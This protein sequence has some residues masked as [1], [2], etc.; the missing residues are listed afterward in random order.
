LN[1]EVTFLTANSITGAPKNVFAPNL[2]SV[3]SSLGFV[4]I[5]NNQ[6]LRLRFV[7]PTDIHF[8]DNSGQ[9]T[10]DWNQATKW[11]ASRVPN[12]ADKVDLSRSQA[13]AVQRVEVTSADAT[14]YQITV[15]DQ[16][17]PITVDIK[18]GKTLSAVTGDITIGQ[19]AVIELGTSGIASDTGTLAVPTT[20]TVTLQDGG[21]LKGNGTV[22]AGN[23]TV[24]NG[25]VS[26]GFSVGQLNV[27][28]NYNQQS[29]GTL[30]IDVTGSNGAQH[31]SVAITAQAQLGGT[32]RV[33]AAGFVPT[34]YG[35]PIP[36]LSAG[37]RISV[38]DD[39]QTTG[40][41]NIY[42]A[43]IYG[44]TGSGAGAPGSGASVDCGVAT[45]IAGF[46]KGDMDRD[47]NEFLDAEDVQVFALALNN[48]LL[49]KLTYGISRNQPGDLD[50]DSLMTFDDIRLF[51]DLMSGSG[52]GSAQFDA[53]FN[54]AMATV[55]EPSSGL[56]LIVGGLCMFVQRRLR[57]RGFA[58]RSQCALRNKRCIREAA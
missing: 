6:D 41:P 10:Q 50:G 47:G 12:T 2:A 34:Q 44:A 18:N 33:N 3:N 29:S 56:I 25:T 16:S 28:G 14:S 55:P 37:S 46:L 13:P 53:V 15:H 20:R 57:P 45:C 7:A 22:S 4:V 58:S 5:K 19:N 42:F 32:L 40:N 1:D 43:P 52:M 17:S 31:D 48:P 11:D 39:V 36:I 54:A 49:Y 51:K 23:L 9:T 26:P 24:S 8:V 21:M 27:T 35:L 38:F 30:Q